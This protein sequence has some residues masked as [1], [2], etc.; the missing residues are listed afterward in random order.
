M[1]Q[2][3]RDEAKALGI[4]HY[5]NKNIDKLKEEIEAKKADKVEEAPVREVPSDGIPEVQ[6][7]AKTEARLKA[8]EDLLVKTQAE[9][10]A[11]KAETAR[12]EGIM[13]KVPTQGI[14]ERP[15]LNTF[16]YRKNEK[17]DIESKQ[18]SPEEAELLYE[19]GYTDSPAKLKE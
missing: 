7:K 14:P 2:E 6:D 1:E 9:N 15:N 18:V 19:R 8:L 16:V 5:W 4:D 13:A 17:G 12:L 11:I 3:I 10:R